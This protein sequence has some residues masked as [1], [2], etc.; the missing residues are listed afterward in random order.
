MDIPLGTVHSKLYEK[1]GE[2]YYK[3]SP[4]FG[5]QIN[6]FLDAPVSKIRID[7]DALVYGAGFYKLRIEFKEQEYAIYKLRIIPTYFW[8]LPFGITFG[9]ISK[10]NKR[11][12]FNAIANS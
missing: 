4:I 5:M 11:T 10:P 6:F 2:S 1:N 9:E 8:V 12:L 7:G 3:I